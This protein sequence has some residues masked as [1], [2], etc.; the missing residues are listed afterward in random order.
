[1]SKIS[2]NHVSLIISDCK[3]SADFYYQ[4]LG[5]EADKNRP[6]LDFPGLWYQLG[7]QQIHMMQVDN[8][9]I[10]VRTPEHGGR[11][12]HLAL[13]VDNL[14]EIKSVLEKMKVNYRSSQSG[15][16][17]LFFKDPD[18]NVLELKEI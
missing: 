1:M 12:R 2:I 5:L 3:T 10:S 6:D 18:N 9:Y 15:R 4:V 13:N 7:E 14:Q 16:K 17:A 11:D 8:P